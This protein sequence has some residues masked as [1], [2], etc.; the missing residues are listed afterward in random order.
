MKYDL[1]FNFRDWIIKFKKS[2]LLNPERIGPN[3]L[4]IRAHKLITQNIELKTLNSDLC[5]K[6]EL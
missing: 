1:G 2:E 4:L 6:V 3:L 5:K